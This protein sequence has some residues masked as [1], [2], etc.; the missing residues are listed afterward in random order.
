MTKYVAMLRGIGP[1]DP[2]MTAA[3]FTTFFE[4]L[5]F[6]GVR[7]VLSSGNIIFESPS[8]NADALAELIEKALPEKLGFK[9]SAVIRSQAELQNIID[10]DPFRGIEQ[11]HNKGTYLL[12]TF[13]K[14]KPDITFKLPHTPENK[15][16]TV[17]G[18][19]DKAIYGSIDLSNS[20]TPDYMAWLEKQFGKDITSRTPKTIRLIL[21]RMDDV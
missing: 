5:G 20:K 6:T 9:R 1:G 11:D 17:L 18:R 2:N 7:V 21:K 16:Y 13:F 12:V 10:L 14:Y 8:S 15:P 4:E 3:K 19:I